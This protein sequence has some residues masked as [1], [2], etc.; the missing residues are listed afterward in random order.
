MRLGLELKN[1]M[2][3]GIVLRRGLSAR[4]LLTAFGVAALA[5]A[6]GDGDPEPNP[7][8]GGTAGVAGKTGS[9]GSGGSTAG[10]GGSTGGGDMSVG[11]SEAGTP[12]TSG[13]GG[14]TAGT[15][16]GG[17]PAEGGM[18]GEPTGE[19]GGAGGEGG[20]PPTEPVP[21]LL[22]GDDYADGVT[23]A[24][25]NGSTNDMSIDSSTAHSGSA[26]LKVVVPA[27]NY[28]GGALVSAAQDLSTYNAVSFW[29][30]ASVA[31][32]LDVV[33]TGDN[34]VTKVHGLE[35]KG[36]SLTTEWQRFVVPLPDPSLLTAET[37]LFH[38][39]EGGENYTL[40]LDDVQY[41]TLEGLAAPVV[42]LTPATANIA[43]NG[44]YPVA[45]PSVTFT[46]DAAA[47]VV[48]AAPAWF[49]FISAN[50]AIATVD[51]N[52]VTGEAEGSTEVTA[53]LHGVAATGKITVNVAVPAVPAVAAADPTNLPEDVISLFS[54][55]FTN[56]P[57]TTWRTDW[58]AGS[59]TTPDLLIGANAIKSYTSLNY[60]G[61]DYTG[62][63]DATEMTHLHVDVWLP[64]T[65][66]FKV[67]L[68][69][70]GPD[71][72]YNDPSFPGKDDKE[73]EVAKTGLAT[74]TWVPL[75][76]ALADYTGL[77][78]GR[79]HLAQ[80]V[81]AA[82]VGLPTVYFDNVYFHK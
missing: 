67:K 77:T 51:G 44:T 7:N 17:T 28:T 72:V 9:S 41:V 21:G 4:F 18:G 11:G 34:A 69:D 13:S 49:E 55:T 58:S 20:A 57:V 66:T 79:A 81:I 56:K 15:D 10:R 62:T 47:I 50:E 64:I 33:G 71:G 36:I 6:C 61:V 60:V 27:G 22:F 30:K 73:F 63:I 42:A 43:P 37:G 52:I 26:S 75:E 1:I 68:V 31:K 35:R 2:K 82:G 59:L 70:F 74:K 78:N 76:F 54:E 24:P 40:W 3:H 80:M 5:T 32:V 53:E 39:A 25:F 19:P 46:V 29:A 16:A 38:F 48:E 12:G 45:S 23:F 14:S 8:T 65:D